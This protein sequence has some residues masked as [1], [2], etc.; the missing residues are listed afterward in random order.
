MK[1][2]MDSNFL[3]QTQTAQELYHNAAEKLPIIDYHC[4]LN[5]EEVAKD[6]CFSSITEL[7]LG[8]DH[9]KWRALR[10]N[11]VDE[12]YITGNASDWEKFQKWAETVP[13]CMRNPIY[14]WTHLELRTAFGIQKLLSPSTAREI[15]EECNEKLSQ[16]EYS[17]RGLMRRY[18]VEVVCTTDDP[19][20]S[21]LHH[22][23]TRD[24]GFEIKMLPTWRPDKAMAIED[25]VAYR[26]YVERLGQAAQCEI[27][28]YTDLVDALQRRHDFFDT[29]G[30]RLSDHG[31]TEFHADDF[32]ETQVNA[33]FRKVMDGQKPTVEETGIFRSALLLEFGRQDAAA[34]W[35]QQYHYGPLRNTNSKMMKRLGPDTGFDSI[36]TVNTA[37]SLARFLDR[38]CRE[39]RLAKT[40][41]YCINPSDNE[42][43]AT[44]IGNFQEG[45]VP[46]KI[47]FG[48]G[49]WFNDQK[50]GI[51][52][53]L[54]ALSQLGL[55]SRF[56][57]MLTD[58]RS[59][60][61]YPRHE[62]FRRILCNILG[63]DVENGELPASEL[64]HIKDI[65]RNICYYNAKRYFNF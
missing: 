8:G 53:Q 63:N 12:H 57:G 29:L 3:L 19:A 45:P 40:I 39:D 20:D 50:D 10:T 15:Y 13:Y 58:S 25:P 41:L 30:C 21:L 60:L 28:T 44:M 5:P 11:G 35:T 14:H 52:R 62:Y 9:Y 64:V 24:S 49:W 48:S 7:W 31:I 36:G 65:V 54:N 34:G 38:L 51:E 6:H 46:G 42:M 2:F 56:V 23:A 22:Q 18:N 43:L 17:A 16:P 61:S 47:Q 59:F 1:E 33:I 4:H 26:I 32:T 27:R 55:L 37:A